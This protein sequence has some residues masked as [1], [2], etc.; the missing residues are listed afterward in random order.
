MGN[1]SLLAWF[2]VWRNLTILSL[3]HRIFTRWADSCAQCR[4]S[5][6]WENLG[7]SV[8]LRLITLLYVQ[9]SRIMPTPL[10]RQLVEWCHG[11]E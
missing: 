9:G 2:S 7:L 8:R 6:L 5:L 1:P 4:Q 10:C 3:P 11:W